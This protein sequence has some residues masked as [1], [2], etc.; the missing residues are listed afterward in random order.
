MHRAL[1]DGGSSPLNHTVLVGEI[2]YS[3]SDYIL[4]LK[5]PSQVRDISAALKLISDEAL[6]RRYFAIQ[7][8]R[9]RALSMQE[10]T[11]ED[12]ARIHTGVPH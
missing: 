9:H 11:L 1:A 2:L 12:F 10:F 7:A 8:D 5:T 4:S 3:R 6:R